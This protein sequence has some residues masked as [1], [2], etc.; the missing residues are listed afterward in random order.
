MRPQKLIIQALG[1][2]ADRE[3]IDFTN[4]GSEQIFVISGK[5]GA[6]KTT[7][8][9]AMSFALFGRANTNERDGSSLRSHFA[10]DDSPTGVELTFTLKSEIYVVRRQPNQEILRKNGEGM[11]SLPAAA[12]LY[13]NGELV[14]KS[15]REV[16]EKIQE[17]LQLN[18]DQFRQI[19]M[20]PQGAFRE[21]L[22]APSKEKQEIL[23]KL[24]HTVIYQEIEN[25]LK[26]QQLEQ[27]NIVEQ[28][29]QML[30]KIKEGIFTE[31]EITEFS[32]NELREQFQQQLTDKR[33]LLKE[34]DD[35]RRVLNMRYDN[36]T[37]DLAIAQT[38]LN[39]WQR[40]ETLQKQFQ[41][42]LAK[43]PQFAEIE[44]KLMI[45]KQAVQLQT[46]DLTYQQAL[47]QKT[48]KETE[49]TKIK[50]QWQADQENLS[51]AK[52]EKAEIDDQVPEQKLKISELHQL[53]L[54]ERNLKR[55][56][57]TKMILT[58]LDEEVE[59][60]VEKQT[61][62]EQ[63]LEKIIFSKETL[64]QNDAEMARA[65]IAKH[66]VENKILE[67]RQ[68]LKEI[69][70]IIAQRTQYE[71]LQ[72]EL[73]Q[74][75]SQHLQASKNF[76]MQQQLVKTNEILLEQHKA[77][78]MAQT[79]VAGSPCPVCGATHHPSPAVSTTQIED[80]SMDYLNEQLQ[81]ASNFFQDI[82]TKIAKN[83]GQLEQLANV[84]DLSLSNLVENQQKLQVFITA[85]EQ[86]LHE[87]QQQLIE[88]DCNTK[89]LQWANKEINELQPQLKT[90]QSQLQ[91]VRAPQQ[92]NRA[93]LEMLEREIPKKYLDVAVFYEYIEKL[94]QTITAFVE[95]QEQITNH[96]Q[97]SREVVSI[98][99]TLHNNIV[100]SLQAA[101]DLVIEQEL[102]LK[103]ALI[104]ADFADYQ[105]Y[106]AA[107]L[108]AEQVNEFEGELE[109]YRQSYY[110]INQTKTELEKIL[111]AE[112][113]PN[114]SE[115]EQKLLNL[116]AAKESA[117]KVVVTIKEQL[118]IFESQGERYN[119]TL[120]TYQQYELV[121]REIGELADVATGKNERNLGFE[122]YVL[123][124]FL[125]TILARTNIRLAQMTNGRFTLSR[126]FEKAK[127]NAQSGLDME[128]FDEYT[129]KLRD[130]KTLSGGESFKTSLALALSLAEVVQEMSGGI[131]LETM[132]IDE[133]FGTLDA[134]S[135]DSAIECLLATQQSGRLVGIISHV[136]ELKSR[137]AVKLE[138]IST[139][140]GSTTKFVKG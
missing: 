106:L 3:V 114:I 124:S 64:M 69:E 63:Q 66:E 120:G 125:D 84:S 6:G 90:L 115:L 55:Y 34:Q 104:A 22:L 45:N 12:T 107:L 130:V 73:Q 67:A 68:Q 16:D 24:A 30:N 92:S 36:S 72:K 48:E 59:S 41:E 134:N 61:T 93:M 102:L 21:L 42:L 123:G 108:T 133:G 40:F 76:E 50:K 8:F 52:N 71:Q 62:I 86:K 112:E 103:S 49:L 32:D 11:R 131:S 119:Q 95:K 116:K 53:E 14:A 7:I 38:R 122:R 110:H 101:N 109:E 1:P 54:I 70:V 111:A 132:F 100:H 128:V 129:G 126:K 89:K 47:A 43:G 75:E 29:A 135:L 58:T 17:V 83:Q 65:K 138:V 85:Q 28:H 121:Y 37:K 23:Q 33:I 39:E 137:I 57:E 56:D 82:T 35:K 98:T 19:L 20:I 105:E 97:K 140:N 46:V 18:V 113:K 99:E 79:L 5:T 74:L 77:A 80:M 27:K 136:P 4:I 51:F 31:A 91:D 44:Q 2:Y 118:S 78:A 94:R 15:V 26:N 25:K 127:Y 9:D 96:F 139:P 60:L 88:E 87:V 117:E 13:K 81:E 10:L